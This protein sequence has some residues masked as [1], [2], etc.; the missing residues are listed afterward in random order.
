MRA[1]RAIGICLVGLVAT[2]SLGVSFLAPTDPR[3]WQS[4]P[5]NLRPSAEHLLGT[6]ALGQD[7]FWLLTWSARN[8]LIL[9][10][11]VAALATVIGVAI[12]LWA[13]YRGSS[14]TP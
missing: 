12:G 6:T 13:G 3:S 2:L 4:Y 10:V 9:G 14:W 8:S 7:T 11:T 1:K 5:R